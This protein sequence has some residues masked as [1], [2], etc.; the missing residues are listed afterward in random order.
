MPTPT[1]TA[2]KVAAMRADRSAGLPVGEVARRNGVGTGTASKYT[3]DACG[4]PKA[5][6]PLGAHERATVAPPAADL[7]VSLAAAYAPFDVT[8]RGAWLV[9]GDVHLPYHDRKTIEL[10]VDEAVRRAAVGVVLNGD[11]LDS[12]DLSEHDKDPGAARYKDEI[13]TGR[14]F[15]AWLRGRLPRARVIFKEG[16]HDDR[17]GR[18]VMARA[19][20]LSGL[21]GVDVP[22]FLQFARHGVEWVG[23]KRV[24]TMGKLHLVHGHEYRGGGGVSPARWLYLKAGYVAMCGHFH[25]SSE[26]TRRNIRGKFEAAWSVGCACHLSPKYGP[27]NDWNNGYAIVEV[28]S[29]GWFNVTNRRV[30]DGRVL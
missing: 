28:E 26:H 4:G 3:R 27:L 25:R 30:I 7:P 13:D 18:Y 8:A 29:D 2:E 14:A 23:D 12:H 1:I 19:P 15:L 5:D 11:V 9:L 6:L 20:A 24:I 10:A 16:N 22:A 17:L 21:D